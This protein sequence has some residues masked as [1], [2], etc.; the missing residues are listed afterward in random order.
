[1][2]PQE[3][4]EQIKFLLSMKHGEQLVSFCAEHKSY[5]TS[6]AVVSADLSKLYS[7]PELTEL[8]AWKNALATTTEIEE[9]DFEK[10][11]IEFIKIHRNI[12]NL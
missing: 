3:E 5:R 2:L 12:S 1:M 6:W 9:D 4:I 8:D 7:M 10:A 11:W